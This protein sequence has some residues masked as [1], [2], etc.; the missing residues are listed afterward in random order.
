LRA[1]ERVP[2]APASLD[3]RDARDSPDGWLVELA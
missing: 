2:G 3:E 1:V